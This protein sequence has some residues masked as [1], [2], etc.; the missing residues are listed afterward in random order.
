MLSDLGISIL[1]S[2]ILGPDY[3]HLHHHHHSHHHHLH[4]HQFIFCC[5]CDLMLDDKKSSQ[6]YF[7]PV[8]E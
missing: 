7:L 6:I 3:H 5:C 4:L 8:Y 2:N 1:K